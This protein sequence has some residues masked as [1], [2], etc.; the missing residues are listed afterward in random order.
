MSIR[1]LLAT[2]LF[3]GGLL[4]PS[5]HAIEINHAPYKPGEAVGVV[6][7]CKEKPATDA[8]IAKVQ[9]SQEALIKFLEIAVLERI[10]VVLPQPFQ[11]TLVSFYRSFKDFEGDLMEMWRVEAVQEVYALLKGSE[12]A[13]VIAKPETRWF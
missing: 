13:P 1:S 8:F 7:M 12:I 10:C 4:L 9:Q 3:V 5:A 2:M 6:I 11:V